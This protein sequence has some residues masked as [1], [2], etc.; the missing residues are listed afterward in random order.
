M[1]AASEGHGVILSWD[2]GIRHL[3]YC[4][5]TARDQVTHWETIDMGVCPTGAPIADGPRNRID[6]K[7]S[8]RLFAHLSCRVP[9]FEAVD[10]VIVEKQPPQNSLMRIIQGQLEMFFLCQ[11]K[12]VH[13]FDGKS[14]LANQSSKD[15]K[16]NQKYRAR[17]KEAIVQCREFLKR[18]DQA[19]WIDTVLDPSKKRDDLADCLL[20]AVRFRELRATG[21]ER[22]PKTRRTTGKTVTITQHT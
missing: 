4:I 17:K 15:L 6:S 2:V 7:T 10:A 19:E 11:K 21:G 9:D 3:A 5:T 22:E 16:G 20:Q 8:A 13:I 1:S 18:T 12:K 14:K